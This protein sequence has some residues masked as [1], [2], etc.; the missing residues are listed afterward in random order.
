MGEVELLVKLQRAE[1]CPGL[2]VCLFRILTNE[3]EHKVT[4]R[5]VNQLL[6]GI[7]LLEVLDLLVR[8]LFDF[9]HALD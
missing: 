5:L 1:Q 9:F 2:S 4:K 7:C 3:I 6:L 8:H